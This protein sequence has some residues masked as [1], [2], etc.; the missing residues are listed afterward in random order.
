MV[1]NSRPRR[2]A[3]L[4]AG[5]LIGTALGAGAA[6]AS[7]SSASSAFSRPLVIP[8]VVTDSNITLTAAET[9]VQILPGAKT[10]M[11]TYNGSFPG[12]TIR[13]PTGQ[14]TTV[15]GVNNL[16]SAA[17][18]L[19]LHHHGNHSSPENDGHPDAFLY[20][21]GGGSTTYTYTGK[22]AGGNE[23]G[24]FQWYHDHRDH[25]TGRNV[26]M[27]LAGMFIYDD[28]ADPQTLPAG[29]FDV[30]LLIAD[31]S[32]DANN[33][34]AY[35]YNSRGVTG[36]HILV[37]GV[38]QPYFEVGDRKYRLRILNASNFRSYDLALSN[39]QSFLQIGTESG[40][41]P[42]PVQRSRILIG[43]AERVEV[44]VDFANQLNGQIVLENRRAWGSQSQLMQFRVTRDLTDNSSVPATL[45]SLPSLDSPSAVTRTFE[46]GQKDG[47]WT[48]N[49]R[50]FD[51]NRVDARPK[52]NTTETWVLKNMG[53][54]DHVIHIHDVDQQLVSRNG[55]APAPYELMKESWNISRGQT[56]VVKL[57]FTG[58]VG[59]YVFHCH[60]LEHEDKA[61]MTQ[62]EV[63]R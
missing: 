40:L 46:F 54:S 29:E 39:G 6:A 8:P 21:P 20:A 38:P 53:W 61:M 58:H 51:S 47:W 27:G 32:F 60:V 48:I 34:L 35:T 50:I 59:R 24:A 57:K 10:R 18:S 31:R 33:Q 5:I 26:W 19:T 15:K 3:L 14:T 16:P 56:V 28:P 49:G 45:R 9:D 42:A 30:P 22:E 23:R 62:F 7:H 4:V 63:V 52:L 25:V 44:V 41:L 55:A 12:P 36:D 11:W 43:P 17:G 37:N 2:M 13:R 1:R